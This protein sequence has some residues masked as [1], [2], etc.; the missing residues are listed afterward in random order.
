[1]RL[2]RQNFS[3][4]GKRNDSW[5]RWDPVYPNSAEIFY[6]V[7]GN[8]GRVPVLVMLS[9]GA[10]HLGPVDRKTR[11]NVLAGS[12]TFTPANKVVRPGDPI[13]LTR[14]SPL[15]FKCEAPVIFSCEY[16][17]VQM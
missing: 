8:E 13:K 9:P 6:A 14:G 17:E 5:Q 12:M 3:E 10:F 16:G 4:V 15:S 1:M 7:D 2:E 11:V